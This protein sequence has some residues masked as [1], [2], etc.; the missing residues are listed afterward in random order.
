MS[1]VRGTVIHK[2]TGAG[3]DGL[4]V[5]AVDLP[6]ATP[7]T[8]LRRRRV[9]GERLGSVITSHGGRFSLTYDV[10]N[11][12]ETNGEAAVRPGRNIAIVVTAPEANRLAPP[13]FVSPKVRIGAG[14]I[15]E[16]VISISAAEAKTGGA[17]LPTE[18]VDPDQGLETDLVNDRRAARLARGRLGAARTRVAQERREAKQYEA[19]RDALVMYLSSAP[20]DVRD[21]ARRASSPA[22][23]V[24]KNRAALADGIRDRFTPGAARALRLTTRFHLNPSQKARLD[25]FSQAG[26][27]LTQA[28]VEKVLASDTST[29]EPPAVLTRM[30]PVLWQAL[31]K[32]SREIVATRLL[33]AEQRSGQGGSPPGGVP[34]NGLGVGTAHETTPDATSS[35][36][37][38]V[39]LDASPQD[40]PITDSDAT[41]SAPF[42]SSNDA[43][44]ALQGHLARLLDGMAAPE[45]P[46]TIPGA[47]TG[48]RADQDD[49]QRAVDAF[50][51]RPGPADVPALFDFHKLQIAF[52]H[53]WQDVVDEEILDTAAEVYRSIRQLGGAPTVAKGGS[54]LRA[55]ADEAVLV[56]RA[57]EQ[58]TGGAATYDLE[59]G[60]LYRR[61]PSAGPPSLA[62]HPQ[63][64][65]E[66]PLG[67]VSVDRPESAVV[68]RPSLT[69]LLS[70]LKRMIDQAY[71]FTVYGADAGSRSVNFGIVITYR[72]T[73]TPVTYQVGRLVASLPLA[74][75]ESRKVARRDVIRRKRADRMLS[76]WDS[77][78]RSEST[79]TS[80][81]EEEIVAKAMAK[82]NFE[83]TTK[84]TYNLGVAEGDSTALLGRDAATDSADTKRTFHEAVIRAVQEYKQEHSTELTTDESTET[85]LSTSQE[86]KNE[87]NELH[88]TYLFYELQRRYRLHER[89]HRVTPVVLVA[90]EVPNPRDITDAWVLAHDWIIRRVLLDEQLLPALDYLASKVAGDRLALDD[91]AANVNAQRTLVN[92]MK[93]DVSALQ[94]E[95]TKRY[96]ALLTAINARADEIGAE[97]TDGFL[98]DTVN[99]FGGG[100]QSTEAAKI[101]EDSARDAQQRAIDEV[102][103]LQMRLQR[104]VTALNELTERYARLRSDHRNRE[105][106]VARLRVHI[107]QNILY[108]MQ[109]VWSFEVPHQRFLRLHQVRVPRFVDNGTTTAP[110]GQQFDGQLAGC[111]LSTGALVTTT[112][113]EVTVDPHLTLDATDDILSEVADLERLLGFHGN[114][115]IF[116]LKQ[117][118]PLTRVLTVPYVDAGWRLMDPD[119][120]KGMT[121]EEF[122]EYVQVLH[123]QLSAQEFETMRP[124]LKAAYTA[125]LESPLRQGEEI[126]V[127]T[128]SLY[129]DAL[130]GTRP[131]LE[132]FKLLHRGLDV[133]MVQAQTRQAEIEN[134]RYAARLVDDRLEDPQVDKRIIVEGGS[135]TVLA[136]E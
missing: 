19:F 118:N 117:Q 77:S 6:Q 31:S 74:P 26:Q 97:D 129:I 44:V 125:L 14:E 41:D 89:I 29:P 70:L 135:T 7:G 122:A 86:I 133:R 69:D 27:P 110:T 22:D 60:T 114:Y 83:L 71:P 3:F 62:G 2:E 111:D 15:E 53:V 104:E 5:S 18:L 24:I 59:A 28:N 30:P 88:V 25:Q 42:G 1:T 128:D 108:Y 49:L 21:P 52:D 35:P 92:T 102:K 17:R 66:S 16:Y 87:N 34:A 134:L 119:E 13:L 56:R 58:F 115:M 123:D 80:R 107:K 47:P 61:Q 101:R 96:E 127:P 84:G 79:S 73:W 121:L 39:P 81:A 4:V 113:V 116:P 55:L 103:N 8:R 51:I 32:T 43:D 76:R 37:M 40:V 106:Q 54:P 131:V 57:N 99:F 48:T 36:G 91:L 120:P 100:G 23:V 20:A 78:E 68:A 72:Q 112:G 94:T 64:G 9:D 33:D 136:T 90:Q 98:A 126:V 65:D 67:D 109:A 75:G 38:S 105:V 95:A 93:G 132:D 85:E 82:T 11:G 46:F 124:A 50:A 130:P 10:S 12:Q 45:D 63:S